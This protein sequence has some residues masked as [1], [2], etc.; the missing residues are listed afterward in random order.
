MNIPHQRDRN[1]SISPTTPY[2][3]LECDTVMLQNYTL[4][5]SNERFCNK[6][7]VI[8]VIPCVCP[9]LLASG[10]LPGKTRLNHGLWGPRRWGGNVT[11][12]RTLQGATHHIP[13]LQVQP[14]VHES[15]QHSQ[16]APASGQVKGRVPLLQEG[17][18]SIAE[19]PRLWGCRATPY[20]IGMK[21]EIQREEV[22][23]PGLRA[24]P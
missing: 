6:K 22:T 8:R 3:V 13:L 15:L 5:I 10:P 17:A 21:T 19:L 1:L 20:F 7:G 18:G 14:D 24:R 11:H 16:V 12:L 2:G 23:P 4:M 9:Q